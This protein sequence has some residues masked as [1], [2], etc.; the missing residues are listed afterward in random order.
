MHASTS[1]TPIEPSARSAP[2]KSTAACED[3]RGVDA[4]VA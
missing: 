4:A 3:A 1:R 2:K